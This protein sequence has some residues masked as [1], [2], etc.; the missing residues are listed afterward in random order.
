MP[1]EKL[2]PQTKVCKLCFKDYK[3]K[4]IT[5]LL[6]TDLRYCSSC[7]KNIRGQF[8]SFD[9]QG[10]KALSIYKYD[11]KIQELLYQLKGCFDIEIADVFLS[12]YWRELHLR[13]FRYLIVPIPSFIKDDQVREFN[14]VEEIFKRLKLPMKKLITKT[15]GVKQANSSFEKRKEIGKYMLLNESVD[16]SKTKILLVDDV[17]TTGST[18]KAAV[19]LIESLY[20]KDIK[21]LVMSKVENKNNIANS[22]NLLFDTF[23]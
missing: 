3:E 21:I 11:S 4:S 15:K 23:S 9:V 2:N 19:K 10:H 20:P 5:H 14:H 17:Y 13:F 16:L 12:R 7:L 18:M 6:N 22:N 8:I 1:L